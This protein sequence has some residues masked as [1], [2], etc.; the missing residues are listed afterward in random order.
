[1]S[2]SEAGTFVWH[3]TSI[4][5]VLLGGQLRANGFGWAAVF[6]HDGLTAAPVDPAW[7]DRFRRASGLALGGWG[8]LRTSPVAEAELA[9]R[10]IARYHLDFYVADAEAEYGYTGPGGWSA[11]RFDRSQQ[12]VGEF[13]RLEPGLPAA[14]ASYCRPDLHDLDWKAWSKG[15]FDFMPEA[16]VNELGPAADPAAC[17]SAASMYFPASRVHPIVG[18]YQGKLGLGLASSYAQLLQKA[19]TT[20]FSI[21]LAEEGMT[22]AKWSAFGKA[23]AQ[24]GIAVRPS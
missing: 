1:M 5:P 14:V 9:H 21:Y 2:W 3:P 20:G 17:A 11:A 23:I 24:M 4:D 6:I 12:F 10:L 19:G 13:R 18:M 22:P 16:Y 8:V 7:I 15:G